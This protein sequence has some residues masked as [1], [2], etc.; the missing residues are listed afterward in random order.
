MKFKLAFG[1]QSGPRLGS[2]ESI[3][4]EQKDLLRVPTE[5]VQIRL[6]TFYRNKSG[7]QPRE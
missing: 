4:C 2:Q 3:I 1:W 6:T 5:F 7:R